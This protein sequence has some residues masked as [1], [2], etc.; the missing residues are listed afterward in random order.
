MMADP[1]W[2]LLPKL[3]PRRE[4]AQARVEGR[5]IPVL[6]NDLPESLPAEK[7]LHGRVETPSNPDLFDHGS[8]EIHLPITGVAKLSPIPFLEQVCDGVAKIR[9]ERTFWWRV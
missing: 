4:T 3:T 9:Q 7:I 2:N 6:P 1:L 5:A 8:M